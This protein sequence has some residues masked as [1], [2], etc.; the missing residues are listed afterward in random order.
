VRPTSV[1]HWAGRAI[2]DAGA[3]IDQVALALGHR[4]LD[5]TATDIGLD[6]RRPGSRQEER[7]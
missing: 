7:A 1:R 6:W 2:Y 5:E 3:R 4:S